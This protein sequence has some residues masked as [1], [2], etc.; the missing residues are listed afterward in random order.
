MG[1]PGSLTYPADSCIVLFDGV[2]NLCS[3]SVQFILKRDRKN[4]FRFASLQSAFGKRTLAELGLP[5]TEL[6]TIIL[7]KNNQFFHRSRAAL[8]IAR[9]LSGLWPLVYALIVVPA[10][11]RDPVYNF[12]ARNRYRWF[13][14]RKT[15]WVPTA[16]WQSKFLDP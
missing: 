13:G 11:I 12:I 15:C 1:S 5:E 10:S 16:E 9:N 4:R 3:G 6:Q 7:L 14:K 8:E 2:C